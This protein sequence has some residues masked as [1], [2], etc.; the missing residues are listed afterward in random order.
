[1]PG[2][3]VLHDALLQDS[4]LQRHSSRALEQMMQEAAVQLL[5]ETQQLQPLAAFSAG[6][7]ASAPGV[8]GMWDVN[9]APLTRC[10]WQSVHG[11]F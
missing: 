11:G 5:S 8:P 4:G 6:S 1:M 2:P 7:T 9:E 10:G 3:L